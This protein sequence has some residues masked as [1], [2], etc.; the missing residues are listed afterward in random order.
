M[1]GKFRMVHCDNK[2]AVMKAWFHN[3]LNEKD[4]E[5]MMNPA[6][7]ITTE[8]TVNEKAVSVTPGYSLKPDLSA[9]IEYTMD[10]EKEMGAP[11]NCKSKLT[12]SGNDIKEVT[13]YDDGSIFTYINTFSS[14]GLTMKCLGSEGYI[15]TVYFEREEVCFTGFYVMESCENMEETILEDS[16]CS[17]ADAAEIMSSIAARIT[18]VN[19]VYTVT[20]YLG[21]G[22]EKSISWKLDEEVAVDHPN[23][24]L[25]GTQIT[26]K[27]AP[28]EYLTTFKD[29]TGKI[30][31]WEC[32]VCENFLKFKINKPLNTK[33]GSIVYRKYP[34]VL[35]TFKTVSITGAEEY[36][37]AIGMAEYGKAFA[38]DRPIST[39]A[40]IG[41]G[42]FQWSSDSKFLDFGPLVW[43]SGE[44]FT[45]MWEGK[46]A[47]EVITLT[48]K[49]LVGVT[50]GESITSPFTSTMGKT[51]LV[52]EET[53]AG[54]PIPKMTYIYARI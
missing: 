32:V 44:E 19:G 11:Y 6:N 41:K 37:A 12:L 24:G 10:Q 16:G 2:A 53:L 13:T 4:M 52:V 47:T 39:L 3:A 5:I 23:L 50:K 48:K 43:K 14:N 25:K 35:G 38:L 30:S 7:I 17:A 22:H 21:N 20:D 8:I 36:F 33:V 9:T 15:G 49:G 34:D 18:L 31:T 28:G 1:N 42:K 45:Y 26:T 40:Y 54:N 46:P 29:L 51:F 27:G